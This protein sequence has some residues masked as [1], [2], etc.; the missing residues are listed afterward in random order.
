MTLDIEIEDKRMAVWEKPRFG[1]IIA[2]KMIRS[3]EDR[4]LETKWELF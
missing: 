4:G 2:E 1:L 3:L